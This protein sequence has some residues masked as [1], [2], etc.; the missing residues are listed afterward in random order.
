MNQTKLLQR[1]LLGLTLFLGACLPAEADLGKAEV[2]ELQKKP[3]P[4][5][6]DAWCVKK[7]AN[8]SVSFNGGSITVDGSS[9]VTRESLVSWKKTTDYIVPEG[10]F[11]VIRPHN[12]YTYFISYI[13]SAGV[14]RYAAI[15]FQHSRTSDLFNQR[16]KIFAPEKEV[17]CAYNFVARETLCE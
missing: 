4:N 17:R 6:F 7:Y 1:L 3:V 15:V 8:C 13:D 16:L 9:G 14:K 12:L 10:A 2:Q 11:N 5:V